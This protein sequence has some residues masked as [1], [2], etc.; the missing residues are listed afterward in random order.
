MRAKCFLV[1]AAAAMVVATAQLSAQQSAAEANAEA[2]R[3]IT[4]EIKDHNELMKNLEYLS[5]MLGP[6][7][8]GSETL[9][10]AN[11]W[12]AEKFKEYSAENVHQEPWTLGRAW[13]RGRAEGRIL[14]PAEHRVTL[15]SYGWAAGTKG[16]VRGPVVYLKVSKLE[17]LEPFK[18]KLKNAVVIL[19]SPRQLEKPPETPLLVP[20]EEYAVPMNAYKPQMNFRFFA[21]IY[22]FLTE[23][24]AGALLMPS[25]KD[26]DLL[27]MFGLGYLGSGADPAM[28]TAESWSV[29]PTPAAYIAWED[30]NLIWR[31]LQRGQ[32]EMELE[33]DNS[34]SDKPVEVYNTVAEIKGSQKPDE[35]VLLGAHLDSWDLGTGATD[36]GTGVAVVLEAARALLR[37]GVKPKRTI[38]F[39]LFTGEEEGAF[40]SKAYVKAHQTELA[41]ISGV[42][43]HD[44]GTGKVV[45]LGLEAN[46][47][48]REV[49]DEV[50]LGSMRDLHLLEPT[51]RPFLSTDNAS[52]NAVGVPGFQAIQE[53]LD[54]NQTHHSQADTFDRVHEDGLIQGAQV[55]ARW[56]FNVA[57][58]PDLLPRKP[59]LQQEKH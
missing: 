12:A 36:N 44:L 16:M 23:Q 6:R 24:G 45:S 9:R 39:V 4:A 25:N 58:L 18:G 55:L 40:G 10:K 59:Q 41:K 32:V 17:D 31:L 38:R 35:V 3:K 49:M 13:T 14:A 33:L 2:N 34:Y 46:Y 29:A 57:E 53:R 48:A 54:Y 50:I 42:L 1:I 21:P 8:T 27:F 47:Q 30:Y 51:L 37:S 56:A 52:F 11:L 43:V 15:A 28:A 26:Y 5:D 22:K 19:F 7:L 20:Y